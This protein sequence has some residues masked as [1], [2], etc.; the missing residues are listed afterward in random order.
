ML[1]PT[2]GTYSNTLHYIIQRRG[3]WYGQCTLC[4]Y[5]QYRLSPTRG[6]DFN[7]LHYTYVVRRGNCYRLI[8]YGT[9]QAFAHKGGH[10]AKHYTIYTG[11]ATGIDN[12]I[13]QADD[14]PGRHVTHYTT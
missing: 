7:T 5:V 8:T 4:N 3:N 13:R 1:S 10:I 6:A 14:H 11:G 9:K 2:R 12:Y